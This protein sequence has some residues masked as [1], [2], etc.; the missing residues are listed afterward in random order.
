MY[1]LAL[2]LAISACGQK[3]GL[4]IPQEQPPARPAATAQEETP[5]AQ[6]QAPTQAPATG[7]ETDAA[8]GDAS[9]TGTVPQSDAAST[10]QPATAD[11]EK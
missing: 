7:L 11:P 1:Y 9:A 8:P 10:A 2:L 5:P 3:G 6:P 4:Y